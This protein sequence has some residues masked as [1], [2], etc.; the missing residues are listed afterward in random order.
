MTWEF[1]G[2]V[3][4]IIWIDIVLS[5]DNALV[6]GMAAA[7][8][9]PHL[10]QKAIIL[11]MSLAIAIRIGCAV[12]ATYLLEIAWIK[13]VGGLA[14]LWVA[15]KLFDE[16]R[17]MNAAAAEDAHDAMALSGAESDRKSMIKA[18]V[19]ITIADISMSVDNVLAVA[20]VA[21]DHRALLIFGLLLSIVLMAFCATMICKVMARYPA[22]T[23]AG[24]VILLYVAGEMLWKS[25]PD[26]ASMIGG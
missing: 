16:A 13:F 22:I 26:M 9:A 20:M 5:G 17:N 24:V 3:L 7:G 6:I 2:E 21:G 23:Y 25:W 18:L 14:L 15:W 4:Q 11:G 12:V 8:L 19:T 1:I 10:R